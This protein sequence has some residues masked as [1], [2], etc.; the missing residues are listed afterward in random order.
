MYK[1]MSQEC[2]Q[3]SKDDKKN[4]HRL[5]PLLLN[6]IYESS[7]MITSLCLPRKYTTTHN[8]VPPTL[9]TGIGHQYNKRLLSTEEVIKN[10]TQITG[11]W[12]KKDCKYEIHL[13]AYVSTKENPQT[14]IRNLIICKE[15]GVVLESIAF[16]ETSLLKLHPELKSTKIYVHFKS[17]DLKYDRTEYWHRLGYWQ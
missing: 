7:D 6:I 14:E 5:D 16:S 9:F 10:Q 1:Q 12:V 3:C 13:K 8:D 11:K 4:Q 15:L 17:I 2:V